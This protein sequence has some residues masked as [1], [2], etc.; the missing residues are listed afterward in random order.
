MPTGH[1]V[2]IGTTRIEIRRYKLYRT[3]R[4]EGG[5][6]EYEHRLVAARML[7]RPLRTDEIVHHKDGNGLNNE[8]ENLEV[9]SKGEHTTEHLT[10]T[11]WAKEHNACR[12]CG[13]THRQHLGF[14]LCSLCY[15]R[16]PGKSWKDRRKHHASSQ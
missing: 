7:G 8:P 12:L 13:A 14:G 10:I 15:Q 3:V 16:Q 2:T 5:R 1:P 4:C 9:L 6:W 11:T